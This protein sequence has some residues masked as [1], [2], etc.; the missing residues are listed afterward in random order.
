MKEV[1]TGFR[2]KAE[3]RAFVEA[4]ENEFRAALRAVCA[5]AAEK[6]RVLTLA[7]PTCSGKTTTA[8]MLQRVFA[9]SGKTL[10]VISIDDFYFDHDRLVANSKGEIDYDSPDTIDLECFGRAVEDIRDGGTFTVPRYDLAKGMRVGTTTLPITERDAYLFE[11]IQAVYPSLTAHFGSYPYTA[12]FIS[13]ESALRVG[14]TV[15]EPREIRFLRRLV[16]DYHF[17][18]ADAAFTFYLWDSVCKN[19]DTNIYP[20][21]SPAA[22]RIDSLLGY[23]L[24]VIKPYALAVLDT[25]PPES[26]Y[27]ERADAIREKLATIPTFPA[28]LVPKDSVFRE[29]I[30]D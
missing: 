30:G 24:F 28:D 2:T 5:E 4:C 1:T 8:A 17:R 25:L 22:K 13:V 20:N 3:K 26:I 6:S 10:H 19:E 21:V 18:A 11:G 9:E 29:F 12:L 15:F 14:D 27:R 7:G 23:E 16:R